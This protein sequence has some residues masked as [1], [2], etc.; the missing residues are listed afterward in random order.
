M[1][2]RFE[3]YTEREQMV[4]SELSFLLAITLGVDI[5]A[6]G[7]FSLVQL[8]VNIIGY[9]RVVKLKFIWVPDYIH[10]RIDLT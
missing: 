8:R 6:E 5:I 1:S 9:G 3:F 4:L 2:L 7:T 10:K